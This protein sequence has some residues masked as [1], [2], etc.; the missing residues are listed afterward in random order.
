M[1][2]SHSP[3]RLD[4][5][6]RHHWRELVPCWGGAQKYSW[7]PARPKSRLGVATASSRCRPNWVIG[8]RAGVRRPS[9]ALPIHRSL[10]QGMY[11]GRARW[12]GSCVLCQR[13]QDQYAQ[14]AG[15]CILGL[16]RFG[17]PHG[18]RTNYASGSRRQALPTHPSQMPE[19]QKI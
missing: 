19:S 1:W 16:A 9:I 14:C 17:P 6:G 12:K 15:L 13:L 3:R 5:F 11:L 18:L 7:H 10:N 8:M 2:A 4:I